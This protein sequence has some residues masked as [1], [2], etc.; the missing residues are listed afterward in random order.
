MFLPPELDLPTYAQRNPDLQAFSQDQLLRHWDE[1]G[2][3]EVRIASTVADRDTF[4]NLLLL[5]H[6]FLEIGVFDRPSLEF[7]RDE[8][9][10][11]HYADWLSKEELVRRA[12]QLPG[13]NPDRVPDI[14]WILAQ[15][16]DQI[17]LKYDAVVS[18]HCVEHQPD[19]IRHFINI[20]SILEPGGCYFFTVPDKRRCFDQFIQETTIVDVL[21][22]YYLERKSPSFKSVLEHRCF[23]NH[24]YPNGDNPYQC[25]DPSLKVKFNRVFEEYKSSPYIDVHCW[26]FTPYSFKELYNQLT[27]LE[28]LPPY[29]ELRVYQ[30]TNEFYVSLVF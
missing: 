8:T 23:I 17:T 29:S 12:S 26:Q 11:I 9:R 4:L 6:T 2:Q 5:K 19:L 28:F 3:R 13:R 10:T 22:A 24:T 14:Q 1:F 20:H 21:E 25:K 7:L 30:G 15:G 18:H 16:Y 27:S